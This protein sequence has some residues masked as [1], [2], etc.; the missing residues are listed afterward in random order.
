M[1][2]FGGLPAKN[3]QI[4]SGGIGRHEADDW[5][6]QI[7]QAGVDFVNISPLRD[8]V[9]HV[10]DA[11]WLPLR[12]NTDV[13]LMLSLAHTLI[14]EGLHDQA[15]LDR[16]R[17]NVH[18]NDG[19]CPGGILGSPS[20]RLIH[21]NYDVNFATYE[22]G[23]EARKSLRFSLRVAVRENDVLTFEV[24]KMAESPLEGVVRN[25]PFG[26]VVQ[27]THPRNFCQLLCLRRRAKCKEQSGKSKAEDRAFSPVGRGLLAIAYIHRI[28][29]SALASTFGGIFRF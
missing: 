8:D 5:L 24:T 29:R 6:A 21:R 16:V 22:V 13:A 11:E 2:L 12:P 28:T 18:H 3:I 4:N 7:R 9:A 23:S 15:Y 14:A 1:V 17:P 26:T 10:L 25:A 20:P 27:V 19:N